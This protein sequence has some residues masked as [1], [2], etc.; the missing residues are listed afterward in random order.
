MKKKFNVTGMTCS[1]CSA[2]VE[3]AVKNVK[4][5]QS[6]DVSLL[7]NS[8]TVRFDEKVA[9]E[10]DIIAAVQ[11]SGYGASAEGNAVAETKKPVGISLFRLLFS[12]AMCVVLMYVS[13]GHM[14]GLPL[15]SF[16]QGTENALSFALVQFLL[17]IPVWYVNRSYFIVGFKRLFQ[18]APNMDSLIAVGSLAG[19]LYGIVTMF[20]E[21]YALGKGDFTTVELYRHELYFESSAMILALVDLGK[22]FEGRSKMKTGDALNKLRKLVPN[23]ALLVKD[24]KETEVDSKSLVA[25]DIVA[26][27]SGMSFPADGIVTEGNCF[28]N[29]SA[30]SGES[31]PVEK[32]PN[33]KVIGGTVNAGGL[34]ACA[35][36]HGRQRQRTVANNHPRGRSGNIQSA[37][38][39]ARRQNF[40]HFCTRCVGYFAG[41]SHRLACLGT[42]IFRGA[43]FCHFGVGNFLPLRSGTG[44]SG[45]YHGGNRQGRRD[46][47]PDQI[48]RE[49]GKSAFCRHR[50]SG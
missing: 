12:L 14:V 45:G 1:A 23:K 18:R 31:L 46:G 17:C 34:C 6:A 10:A 42:D 4:G 43:W 38:S 26:V 39:K 8:M 16:L 41:N 24:G 29:E 25:G 33:D 13:M 7:T 48:G 44:H 11:K 36:H 40:R 21:S 32:L 3:K 5:V 50:C 30:I 28:A 20:I 2:H 49:P 9:S 35:C 47:H 37:H 15:P 22:Y 27:K 19:A